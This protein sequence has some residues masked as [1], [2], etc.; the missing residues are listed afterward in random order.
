MIMTDP[1]ADMLTRVRNAT[2]AR[3]RKLTM[4]CSNLKLAIAKILREEGYIRDCEKHEDNKQGI[5]EIWLKYDSE[6]LPALEGLQRVSRPG[7]RR[8]VSGSE[9]PRVLGG[10][11]VAILSTSR[12]VVTG[13]TARREG[14]GGEVLCHVW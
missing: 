10:L 12:G 11:G 3:H 4:P 6:G 5:L 14:I 1:I 13:K 9:L 2:K 8:Y 7:L